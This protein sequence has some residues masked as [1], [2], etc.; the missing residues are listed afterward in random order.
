MCLPTVIL[1]C[2][3]AGSGKTTYARAR[4]AEGYLL[5][6]MDRLVRERFGVYGVDIPVENYQRYNDAVRPELERRL[7]EA[8]RAGRDVVLDSPLPHRADRDAYKELVASAGGRWRLIHF[9][10][11]P[12]ELRR[13]VR[14]RRDSQAADPDSFP[15]TDE[16]LAFFHANFEPPRGEGEEV[17]AG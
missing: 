3:S 17:V 2:G 8:I 12:A 10:V 6:S 11:D 7:V 4:E 9:D 16:Q 14:A 15:A 1:T 13:R 5:L